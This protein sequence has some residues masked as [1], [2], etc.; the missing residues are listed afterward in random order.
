M[1]VSYGFRMMT[2]NSS[3]FIR[4]YHTVLLPLPRL[5]SSSS[6]CHFN[7]SSCCVFSNVFVCT[8]RKF[9][10]RE[11]P[12]IYN[13]PLNQPK[14]ERK[15]ED[16]WWRE[17]GDSQGD[18]FYHYRVCNNNSIACKRSLLESQSCHHLHR[19]TLTMWLLDNGW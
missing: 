10:E 9:L 14:N 2:V 1:T 19:F 11:P 18:M 6:Q 16:G 3:A 5:S 8:M 15:A 17:D 12:S 4:R 7:L 13:Q